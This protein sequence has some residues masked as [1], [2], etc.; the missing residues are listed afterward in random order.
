MF[1]TCLRTVPGE[2][3]SAAAISTLVRLGPEFENL[4]LAR[5]QPGHLRPLLE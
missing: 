3:Q 4:A 1:S 5:R 2:S